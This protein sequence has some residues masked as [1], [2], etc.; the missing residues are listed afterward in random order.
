MAVILGDR[1]PSIRTQ[2]M[3][4]C[5]ACPL[6]LHTREALS[7]HWHALHTRTDHRCGECPCTFLS[8]DRLVRHVRKHKGLPPFACAVPQCTAAFQSRANLMRHM[9]RWHANEAIPAGIIA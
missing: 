8:R 3:F 6:I 1:L 4:A 7:A 2:S 9:A 5:A